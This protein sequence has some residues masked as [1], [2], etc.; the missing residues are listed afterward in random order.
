MTNTEPFRTEFRNAVAVITLDRP[1]RLNALTFEVYRELTDYFA[2]LRDNQQ[3]RA[4]LLR[5]EGAS[6]CSG[7]DVKDIIGP[8]FG[9]DMRGTLEFT[10]LTGELVANIIKCGKPVVAELK[11]TVAGA[12][13]VI[14]LAADLRIASTDCRLAFLFSQVGLAGCDMGA[15]YLLPRVIGLG[16]ALELLY[17]G[18]FV[19][20]AEA[21]RIG[22]V[23]RVVERDGLEDAT[24]RLADDLSN[25]PALGV[26]MTKEILFKELNMDLDA[27]IEAEAQ[28]QA[29]CMKHA[30]FREGYE[31][32]LGRRP[33]KF[34][35]DS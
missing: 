27:A 23:N 5:G 30:D 1:K 11:G 20:A 18:S 32:F 24:G 34:N 2:G 10:R 4:V 26:S 12:G 31:A 9:R 19:D 29:I 8:L 3:V 17:T 35:Q 7:G 22:L 15:A 14:A 25:L 28:A 21:H 33:A 6:F 16:R 13:A